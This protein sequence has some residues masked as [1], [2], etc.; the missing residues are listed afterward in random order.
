M[1]FLWIIANRGAVEKWILGQRREDILRR[2]KALKE[3]SDA[4]PAF[5]WRDM[6]ETH[7]S[8]GQSPNHI[9]TKIVTMTYPNLTRDDGLE[10]SDR[11]GISLP[12]MPNQA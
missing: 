8:L 3:F 11:G 1:V 4:S 2:G 10:N 5:Q 6:T 7:Q 9:P 12:G